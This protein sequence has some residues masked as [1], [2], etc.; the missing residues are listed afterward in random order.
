METQGFKTSSGHVLAFGAWNNFGGPCS[1][2][3]T[4]P[5][6]QSVYI[7]FDATG[8]SKRVSRATPSGY[9]AV[10]MALYMERDAEGYAVHCF[11]GLQ[12]DA[13]AEAMAATPGDGTDIAAAMR[14]DAIAQALALINRCFDRKVTLADAAKARDILALRGAYGDATVRIAEFVARVWKEATER[15]AAE[16]LP[17]GPPICEACEG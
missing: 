1:Y 5:K 13:V 4:G 8:E 7:R 6:R 3:V 15:A 2:R 12:Y 10:S 17:G 11:G 14:R 9:D 16:A